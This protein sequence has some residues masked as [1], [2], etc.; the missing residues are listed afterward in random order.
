MNRYASDK[1]ITLVFPAYN[2]ADR[3]EQAVLN[4]REALMSISKSFEIIIAEDGS[5][6]GTREIAE[7][8]SSEN[9]S[10]VCIHSNERL[11][12]GGALKRAFRSSKGSILAYLDVDLSTQ[13][14]FLEPL[15]K[16]IRDGYDLA[17]GS[18]ML[19]ESIVQRS[20]LRR[21]FSRVYN[22]MVR[23]L[24]R[25]PIKD[26]QCGFK[27]F[28]RESLFK[29]LDE[30]KDRHW[31]WDTEAIA[32]AVRYGFRIKEIPVVWREGESSKV[33]L[34]SD[35]INMGFGVF[36]LWWRLKM[37]RKIWKKHDR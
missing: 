22:G 17:T 4:A 34:V 9:D 6:D 8:I 15:I 28:K 2:E 13:M 14:N 19:P 24:I 16:S 18:R 12:R 33:K 7:R 30:T 10:V 3:I 29:I 36:S 5:T 31:F 32:L 1:E 11:G 21:L 25:S 27:A 20:L 26:H 23:L 35:A 37:K